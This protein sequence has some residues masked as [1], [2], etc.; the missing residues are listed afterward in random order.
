MKLSIPAFGLLLSALTSPALA[1]E[2]FSGPFVGVQAG[3]ERSELGTVSGP[4][5]TS[6]IGR[7]NDTVTG[8]IFAGYDYKLSPRV[9]LGAE[10][11]INLTDND[12]L[13]TTVGGNRIAI[14]P[15]RSMDL[16]ARLGYLVDDRTLL[17]ARGGYTN[18]RAETTIA[19][20][21]T[22]R[23]GIS[24]LD[25]WLIGAGLERSL[26]DSISTRLEYRYSDLSE[27]DGEFDRHQVLFGVAYRF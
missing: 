15:E 22:L 25:G 18:V 21:T 24:N 23:S 6:A 16:S 14:D 4:L 10:A 2:P 19:N 26:S 8:G 20:A 1:A 5:G 11:G 12:D 27:G 7:S 13:G 3:Y 9:V 17:Y